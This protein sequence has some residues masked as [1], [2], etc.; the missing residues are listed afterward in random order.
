MFAPSIVPLK[1]CNGHRSCFFVMDI[2][3]ASVID[4]RLAKHDPA[5]QDLPRSKIIHKLLP[6]QFQAPRPSSIVFAGSTDDDRFLKHDP[7]LNN[8]PR[9]AT[10][11]LSQAPGSLLFS[12]TGS[13][14]VRTI[15]AMSTVTGPG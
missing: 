10:I 12:P 6:V 14:T 3:L 13:I 1:F 8:H 15:E 5:T 11:D 7:P 4:D 9:F 2:D